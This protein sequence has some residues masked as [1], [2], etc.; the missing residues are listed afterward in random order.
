MLSSD[1]DAAHCR[2]QELP[3]LTD[4]SRTGRINGIGGQNRDEIVFSAPS[5]WRLLLGW[6]VS[7]IIQFA[8][9]FFKIWD[10]NVF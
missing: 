10:M 1:R 6:N 8:T 3:V 4:A 2:A 5:A 9:L 7:K